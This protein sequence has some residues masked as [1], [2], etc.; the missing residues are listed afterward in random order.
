MQL[1]AYLND[2]YEKEMQAK[3]D[4]LAGKTTST[5]KK[6]S[7]G[8]MGALGSAVSSAIGPDNAKALSGFLKLPGVKSV[9]GTIG[10]PALAAAAT[11]LGFPAAAP[12][13]A[14]LTPKA[15]AFAADVVNEAASPSSSGTTSSGTTSSSTT[16]KQE[17]LAMMQIQRLMD[18]QKEMFSLVSNILKSSHDTRMAAINNV[19]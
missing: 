7:S 9:L 2:K 11:A 15:V 17:E 16:G 18:K 3:M 13:L 5:T 14:K 6:R 1:L 4:E 19:R 12:L 10:G 8:I